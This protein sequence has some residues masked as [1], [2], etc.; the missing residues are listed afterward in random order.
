METGRADAHLSR[1]DN[2]VWLAFALAVI[3]G[4]GNAIAIRFTVMELP[5]FWGAA[6]RFG[7][8]AAL[9]WGIVMI[10]RIPLPPRRAL[11]A[12]LLFGLVSFGVALAFV[13][14]GLRTVEPGMA[15]VLLASLRS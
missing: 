5:P 9:L 8:A 15:Q 10:R 7:G 6:L 13:Y 1:P 3:L 2:R 11:P 4:G 14:A 12:V